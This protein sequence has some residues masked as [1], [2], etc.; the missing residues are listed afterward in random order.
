MLE[1]RILV[2]PERFQ[3]NRRG[4]T[5]HG[6]E[7]PPGDEPTVAPKR[8]Q[9][10]DTMAV[11]CDGKGLPVLNGIHDLPRLG[12]QVPLRD[13]FVAALPAF[14]RRYSLRCRGLLIAKPKLAAAYPLVPWKYG[15]A[16]EDLSVAA[17]IPGGAPA[18]AVTASPA[19]GTIV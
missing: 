4:L 13:L 1:R 12:P 15:R 8:D 3:V 7:L 17:R 6:N 2:G 19:S 5:R 10:P 9:F 11:P 16:R 14:R 18:P